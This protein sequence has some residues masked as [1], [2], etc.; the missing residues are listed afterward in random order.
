MAIPAVLSTT[1]E[2]HLADLIAAEEHEGKQLEYKREIAVSSTDQKRKFF[3]SVASFANASGGD[4]IF[5]MVA[6]KGKPTEIKPLPDFEPDGSVRV[7][8]DIIR[9][10]V[11][12]P[13]FGVEFQPVSI[14]GGWALVLR[15]PRSW[16]PPHMVT[17]ESD[18]RFYTRDTNGCVSMNV[19]EIREAFFAGKTV[20]E[21]IHQ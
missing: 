13:L 20:K 5:G 4:F 1:T 2:Q 14:K 21:R 3:R 19:P 9:A 6:D 16:N 18:N 17:F 8:R 15:V 11:D 7:L 12:P 10:H